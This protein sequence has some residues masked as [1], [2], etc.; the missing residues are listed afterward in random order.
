MVPS[1]MHDGSRAVSYNPVFLRSGLPPP[2]SRGV[3]KY[4]G[5]WPCS[6]LI[7]Q[8]VQKLPQPA[9]GPR[10]PAMEQRFLGRVKEDWNSADVAPEVQPPPSEC[11]AESG[12]WPLPFY[13]VLDEFSG[14]HDDFGCKLLSSPCWRL[15]FPFVGD[16]LGPRAPSTLE[17]SPAQLAP[18][19]ERDPAPEPD[20]RLLQQLAL[21]RPTGPRD[22]QQDVETPDSGPPSEDRSPPAPSRWSRDGLVSGCFEW[23]GRTLRALSCCGRC[24]SVFGA[25]EPLI[26]A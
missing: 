9:A 20:G 2:T 23:I 12:P 1:R 21:A 5:P 13:P 26:A 4:P 14:D 16:R 8:S 18:G 24:W 10:S 3:H 15:H 22:R 17:P 19:G 25:K 11:L 6:R 7:P